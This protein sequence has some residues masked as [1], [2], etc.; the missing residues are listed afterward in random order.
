M[1]VFGF[2]PLGGHGGMLLFDL[3]FFKALAKQDLNVTWVTCDET[4]VQ[5][6]GYELWTPFRGIYGKSH[7][8][9]RGL[10]Y[11]RGW[12][13]LLQ[14][15]R[16]ELNH[17][18]VVIHQQFVTLPPV[19]LV[20]VLT[21]QRLGIPCVLTPHDV[22]LSVDV[23]HTSWLLR[24]L[25]RQF[26]ALIVHS[27]NAR[28]E[29]ERILGDNTSPIYLI[30]HGH[31]NDSHGDGP[32]LEQT[33]A[34][35]RLGIP[36]DSHVIVLIGNIK[37]EKGL[38]YLLRA[39]PLVLRDLPNTILLVGGRPQHHDVGFYERLIDE[40]GIRS[41]VRVRWEYLPDE[42]LPL[43][44]R[45]A[46]VVAL[47]YIQAYQ[48]GVCLTAY[49]YYRPVVASAVGGLTE[50]VLDGETGYL[51]PPADLQALADT[52]IKILRDRAL[53]TAMGERGHNWATEHL[54]WDMIAAQ[55]AK[56]YQMAWHKTGK[57]GSES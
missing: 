38:E 2:E 39:I 10:R 26:D 11:M 54:D 13:K 29:L 45:S 56:V 57:S 28:A 24:R 7:T 22:T 34:R 31:Y 1:Q 17:H 46:D 25:Y 21:A 36:Q 19:E 15:A 53:A 32:K 42:E 23:S 40:L 5:S 14:R 41:H 12:W 50:Q 55:T 44:Y 20:C 30:P 27:E 9:R 47:P 3:A 8:W 6:E 4:Q 49:A 48:S 52:L 18:P 43:Y 33:V 37:P 16:E 35:M 51:V